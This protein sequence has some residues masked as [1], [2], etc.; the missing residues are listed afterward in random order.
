[1]LA[2]AADKSFNC[3][4]VDGHTSTNDTVLLLANGQS[5]SASLTGE[6]LVSFQHA[7]DET[8]ADLA[9]SIVADGEGAKHRITIDVCD[10]RQQDEALRIAKSVANSP[11]VKTAVT[12]A[13]PNW[14]RIVSAAGYAGV[15]FDP[16]QLDVSINGIVIFRGGA[17]MIFDHGALSSS[18]RD[19]FETK[20]VLNFNEG[21]AQVRFWTCDLTEEYIRINA[22]YHT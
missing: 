21:P 20:I 7:L 4:S 17:P 16:N 13:D 19:N 3:I 10:C 2:R 14:G 11:L 15:A 22:E 9:Q 5:N 6:E 18:M 12:G 1:L 8:C